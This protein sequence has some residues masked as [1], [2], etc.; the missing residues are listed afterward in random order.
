MW[1]LISLELKKFIS[2]KHHWFLLFI[3]CF[4]LGSDVYSKI[5]SQIPITKLLD[6]QVVYESYNLA[7][8]SSEIR[9]QMSEYP[10][11]QVFPQ[12]IEWL[13]T[14]TYY[15]YDMMLALVKENWTSLYLEGRLASDTLRLEHLEETKSFNVW[16]N[17]KQELQDRIEENTILLQQDIIPMDTQ[18]SMT[19]YNFLI[20]LFS[21][22]FIYLIFALCVYF[23]CSILPSEFEKGTYKLLLTQPISKTKILFSKLIAALLINYT[24]SLI[25]IGTSLIYV[26]TKCGMGDPRY[27]IKLLVNGTQ[28][29]TSIQTFVSLLILFIFLFV[30]VMT[31]LTI[32][33]SILIK[34]ST[35]TLV[36]TGAIIVIFTTLPLQG[37]LTGIAHFNPFTYLMSVDTLKGNLAYFLNNNQLNFTYGIFSLLT[38]IILLLIT[39]TLAFKHQ[40]QKN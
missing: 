25:I 31:V 35:F 9:S 5:N 1:A 8:K 6:N 26:S 32:S 37:I 22:T 23:S 36:I 39:G 19:G 24:W 27:P 2:Q 16:S 38:F 17:T 28:T 4:L 10:D 20:L 29:Y 14:D 30:T 3:F 15:N 40:Q 12:V 34:N 11:N 21:G 33:I 13:E 18:T 7:A